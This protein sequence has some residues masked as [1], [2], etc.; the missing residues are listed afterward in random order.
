MNFYYLRHDNSGVATFGVIKAAGASSSS[1]LWVVPGTGYKGLAFAEANLGYNA[2]MF[3][4]VRNDATGV[5]WFGTINPTPGGIATDLYA[6]GTDF[7][8]LVFVPGAVSTWGSGIF[9]YLRHDDTG[10][11][12]GT[13]D[14][15]THLVTDRLSLG[16]NFLNAL[17]FTATD[18]GYGPNLFYYLRPERS[19]LTTNIVNIYTTNSVVSFTP[20]NTVTATGM[21]ICKVRTVSAAANC[22]GPVAA[23]LVP[24]IRASTTAK[25]IFSLS[26]STEDG[27]S[28]TVQYKNGFNDPTWTDLETVVGTGTYLP[29]TDATAAQQPSRFY[30]VIMSTP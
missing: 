20:T 10:S 29:I 17:T 11:I 23:Q 21:D 6:V 3:Y 25:G 15:V 16:T 8:A 5:A 4:Y 1:D 9:A 28:Y 14:P 7:D 2:N 24:V 30:R 13:I 27:K 19:I 22:L 26:F 12:I 18:V